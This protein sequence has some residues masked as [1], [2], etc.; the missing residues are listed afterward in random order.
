MR[1]NQEASG[2]GSHIPPQPAPT[3]GGLVRNLMPDQ[4]DPKLLNRVAAG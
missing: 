3:V 2:N 4:P 1:L